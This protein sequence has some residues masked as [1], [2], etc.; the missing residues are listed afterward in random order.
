MGGQLHT[1]MYDKRDDLVESKMLLFAQFKKSLSFY[2]H[3]Y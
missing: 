3:H 1:S 2:I